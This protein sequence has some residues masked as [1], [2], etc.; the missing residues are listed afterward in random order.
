MNAQPTV[1]E[2]IQ[3]IRKERGYS[4]RKLALASG[5]SNTTISRLENDLIENPEVETLKKVEAALRLF[6]NQL[7]SIAYPYL[8]TSPTPG[9]S[10]S[11]HTGNIKRI[12]VYNQLRNEEPFFVQEEIDYY[13]YITDHELIGEDCFYL[14]VTGDW[15]T[16]SRLYIGDLILVKRQQQYENGDVIVLQSANKE[17]SIKR[18][19]KTDTTVVLMPDSHNSMHQPEIFT[20]KELQNKKIKIIG[21]IVYAKIR[22]D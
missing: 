22:I 8:K 1:G 19:F 15:M 20:V 21:K 7:V 6:E 10:D 16:K 14:K 9:E 4:Q 12:P 11:E 13:E 5:L 3:L 18:L 17:I 2:Y